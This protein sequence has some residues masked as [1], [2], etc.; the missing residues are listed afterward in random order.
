MS[1]LSLLYSAIDRVG[2]LEAWRRLRPGRLVLCYHNVVGNGSKPRGDAALHMPLEVFEAQMD[3]VQRSYQVVPLAECLAES[4]RGTTEERPLASITF[5][6]AYV[7]VLE[8]ALPALRARGIPA[9]VFVATDATE[10]PAH[11]WWDLLA[12][13]RPQLDRLKLRNRFGGRSREILAFADLSG[14]ERPLPEEYLPANWTA[15]RA[16]GGAGLA[17]G[18]HTRSHPMLTMQT[19]A[20]LELELVGVFELLD[21]HLENVMPILAYPYGDWDDRVANVAAAAGFRAAMTTR[22]GLIRHQDP[23]QLPRLNVPST[24]RQPAFRV[25]ASGLR[26]RPMPR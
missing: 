26:F 22:A 6:D 3:W 10:H 19:Q 11:F 13:L 18:A 23:M 5:D 16:A 17:F 4:W 21:Q 14:E 2:A 7:G 20:Q 8:H 25:E 24:M 12:E 9:T 15:L 1:R